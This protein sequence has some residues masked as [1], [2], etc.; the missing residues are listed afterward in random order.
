M[1][2]IRSSRRIN[3]LDINKNVV[4][5]GVALPLNSVNIFNGTPTTREQIKTNLLNL[6]L[7]EKGERI[8]HPN[9]GLGVKKLL[10]EN[11]VDLGAVKEN[12]NQQVLFFIPEINI[13]KTDIST[14]EDQHTVQ[15]KITYEINLTPGDLDA[16]Q[17]NIDPYSQN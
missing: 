10:F 16:I 6:I 17:I 14:S 12:I 11:D 2:I 9:Y 3:P 15:I 5:I 13:R 7:T 1:A 4:T 8:N